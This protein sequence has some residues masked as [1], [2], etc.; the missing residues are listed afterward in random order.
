MLTDDSAVEQRAV[1]LAFRGLAEGEAEVSHFLCRVHSQRTLDRRFSSKNPGFGELRRH[2]MAALY[3]RKTGP[4]CED[5]VRAAIKAAPTKKDKDYLEKEW[6]ITREQWALYAR[7]SYAVLLQM[8]DTNNVES[9][10][11]ALKHGQAQKMPWWSLYGLVIHVANRP[12]EYDL[13][14][15]RACEDF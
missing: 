1:P 10:H 6:M 11:H 4:G 2:I 14:A 3:A 12:I 9:W 8:P 7:S 13:R 15:E 5:S